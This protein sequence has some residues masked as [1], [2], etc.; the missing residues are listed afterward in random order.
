LD[1]THT[2]ITRL[3]RVIQQPARQRGRKDLMR[4]GHGTLDYPHEAGNDGE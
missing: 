3:D 1:K 4:R 2:V